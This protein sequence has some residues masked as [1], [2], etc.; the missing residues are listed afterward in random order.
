MCCGRN[1]KGPQYNAPH[2]VTTAPAP[3]SAGAQFGSMFRYLG[4]TAL[5]VV[6]PI[7]GTRYRFDQPGSQQRVDLRDSPALLRVPVLKSVG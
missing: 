4:R 7:T 1:R 2:R 3:A 5:T 6:G